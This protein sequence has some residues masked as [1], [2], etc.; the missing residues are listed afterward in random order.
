MQQFAIKLAYVIIFLCTAVLSLQSIIEPDLWWQLAT[1]KQILQNLRVPTYDTFSFSFSGAPWIN[2]K[3]GSELLMAIIESKLGPECVPLLQ[4]VVWL[5]ILALIT[6]HVD[7]SSAFIS[8]HTYKTAVILI[9]LG[10]S[11]LSISYRMN[12]RPEMFTHLFTVAFIY[13]LKSKIA[14]RST[15]LFIFV[16]QVCWTNLHE[17]FGMGVVICSVYTAGYLADYLIRREKYILQEVIHSCIATLIA[18]A[19][20]AINPYGTRMYGQVYEI[21]TQLG[22]NKFTTE[23]EPYTSYFYWKWPA[24]FQLILLLGSV[25]YM[26]LNLFKIKRGERLQHLSLTYGMSSIILL[27][28]FTYLAKDAYRNILFIYWAIIPFLIPLTLAIIKLPEKYF[29][30]YKPLNMISTIVIVW[31]LIFY[32]GI[33]NNTFYQLTNTN[34][35][36]GLQVHSANNPVGAA[37]FMKSEDMQ[38]QKLYTDYLSSSYFL[39]KLQPDFRSFIDLRDLDIFPDSFFQVNTEAV[40]FYDKFK[41]L[42]QTYSFSGAAI[43]NN[44]FDRLCKNLYKDTTYT[45]IYADALI[46]IFSKM[47]SKKSDMT[48]AFRAH[49]T[50]VSGLFA[51]TI[52]HLFNPWWKPYEPTLAETNDAMLTYYKRMGDNQKMLQLL[53]NLKRNNKQLSITTLNISGSYYLEKAIADTTGRQESL[54]S[55]RHYFDL[56]VKLEAGNA[57][58]HFN[59]GLYYLNTGNYKKGALS[60]A[61]SAELKPDFVNGHLY[62]AECYKMLVEGSK[63]AAYIDELIY[64]LKRADKMMPNNPNV[65]WNLGI[66][67]YRKRD[68]NKALPLLE[69]SLLFK[70]LSEEDRI[71]AKQSI[72]GCR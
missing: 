1:G 50:S 30:R 72:E 61:E 44:Q 12:A 5:G 33:V 19:A 41:L 22:S 46:S 13:L 38:Q 60:F 15:L 14:N 28:A 40:Y 23:L 53:E 69:Q 56:A 37:V 55:A 42:E 64:H 25:I 45:L 8:N 70:E 18:F 66:A 58:S 31:H 17:A 43:L 4:S 32:A 21:Y 10:L 63:T 34:Q 26:I 67:Y 24:Y 52:N 39:Y 7:S 9:I 2:I 35:C 20:I 36:F 16:L 62:A 27:V 48:D 49:P 59:Y 11:L 51:T 68:C 54:D 65:I 29:K 6:R 71:I 3:W 47:Q 57:E